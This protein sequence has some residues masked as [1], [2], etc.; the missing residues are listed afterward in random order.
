LVE[1]EEK[2]GN[3]MIKVEK[4]GNQHKFDEVKKYLRVLG[5]CSP[6]DKKILVTGMQDSG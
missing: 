6:K 1:H 2:V 3:K 5:R 4:V